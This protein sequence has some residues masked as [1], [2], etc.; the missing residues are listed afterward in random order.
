MQ[1]LMIDQSAV[2]ECLRSD[3]PKT[4]HVAHAPFPWLRT[5]RKKEEERLQEQKVEEGHREHCP[6]VMTR[7]LYS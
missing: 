3:P 5:M 2:N 7:L 6:L 4:G 1:K